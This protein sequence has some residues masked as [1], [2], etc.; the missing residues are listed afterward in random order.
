[1]IIQPLTEQQIE[2]TFLKSGAGLAAL[3]QL[4]ERD[5]EL[6][7]FAKT[8]LILSIMI[9]TYRNA[10]R[11]YLAALEKV[12][13]YRKHLFDDY[14]EQMFNT[15]ALTIATTPE[16]TK[17]WLAWLGSEILKRGQTILNVEDIRQIGPGFLE[18]NL[19]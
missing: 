2:Q 9:K 5:P 14:I 4:L 15:E 8:P 6:R 7:E 19:G 3:A 11:E 17:L 10:S 18:R 12:R 16:K 13:D 1:V